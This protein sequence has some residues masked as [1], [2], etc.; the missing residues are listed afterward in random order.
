MGGEVGALVAPSCG[1]ASLGGQM[2]AASSLEAIRAASC[3]VA[4]VPVFPLVHGFGIFLQV[5]LVV[6]PSSA[7][8]RR[9]ALFPA[10]LFRSFRPWQLTQM[11]SFQTQQSKATRE[12]GD[13]IQ[14]D[15]RTFDRTIFTE[16]LP[17]LEVVN[18]RAKVFDVEVDIRGESAEFL[19]SLSPRFV[20]SRGEDVSIYVLSI[21]A[22]DRV[23][24]LHVVG[25]V[26]K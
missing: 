14:H 26:A 1:V 20:L 23:R 8:G 17:E 3:G 10:R 13:I 18:F 25:I 12:M 15:L 9:K 2:E 16:K 5:L 19:L 21:Q 22:E 7:S 6:E 4:S 24:G 11:R